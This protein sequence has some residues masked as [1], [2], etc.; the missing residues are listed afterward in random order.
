MDLHG[1]DARRRGELRPGPYVKLTVSDTGHGMDRDTMDRIFEPFF[2]TKGKGEGAG[3]GLAVIHGIVKSLDGDIEVYSEPR[4]G[5]V[6]NVYI[7]R[8]ESAAEDNAKPAETIPHGTESILFVDDEPVLVE[9]TNE[10]LEAIGYKVTS[11]TLGTEA[12]ETFKKA[13]D[14]FDLIITDMTMPKMTGERLARECLKIRPDIPIIL[15]TGFSELITEEKAREAGIRAY[16]MKPLLLSEL[17]R[18]IRD[19]L[20]E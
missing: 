3:M 18:T 17:A 2:T 13:P 5:T 4:R 12:F 7:P 19:V 9:I 16:M 1:D 6:F 14:Q 15:C 10:M 8:I 20:D 11:K